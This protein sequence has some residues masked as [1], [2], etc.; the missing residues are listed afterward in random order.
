VYAVRLAICELNGAG[1]SIP[2]SCLPVTFPPPRK[3]GIFG[4]PPKSKL[5][6]NTADSI[7]AQVLES[8]LKSL[9]SRPQ[10]W[11]S[12]SNSRQN[13]F[14]ICQASRI[15]SEKEELLSLH[16]SVVESSRKLNQGLDEALRT[17]AAES[18]QHRAFVREVE[19]LN[20]KLAQD[21]DE[22]QSRLKAVFEKVFY[23]IEAKAV[24]VANTVASVLGRVQD[25]TTA[26]DKVFL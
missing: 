12:Y 6:V 8:C 24:S 2:P 7:S 18:V 1:T 17:A 25:R 19:A 3:K 20:A 11:T 26:L 15:E 10:W 9:E 23:N 4:F 22:T 13:A 21:I 16:K 14:I 5:P